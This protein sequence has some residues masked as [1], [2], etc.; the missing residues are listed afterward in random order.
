MKLT[1]YPTRERIPV[2]TRLLTFFAQQGAENLYEEDP[3]LSSLL[4]GEYHRQANVLAMVASSSIEHASVLACQ[5]TMLTNV[6]AEGYPGKRYHGGCRYVD[7][8]EQLAID[9]AKLAFHAQ[10]ANV[11]PHCA[12][13]ANEIVM[14]RLLSPGDTIL[15]MGLESGGHLTHGAK[16]SLSGRYFNAI[17]YGLDASGVID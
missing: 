17:E 13:S 11:Q 12:S 4:E 15:G 7:E 10:Y 14:C 8:V 2:S 16:A 1:N 5:G 6:T 9:R 3:V